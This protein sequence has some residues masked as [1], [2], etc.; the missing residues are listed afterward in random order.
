L[1]IVE[2]IPQ[3]EQTRSV[4]KAAAVNQYSNP[5]QK[6]AQGSKGK[7][8]EKAASFDA[9][10]FSLVKVNICLLPIDFQFQRS[11]L[12]FFSAQEDFL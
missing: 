7:A 6:T 3:S 2:E 9:H 8:T 5:T 4:E 11:L 12:R 10:G 1:N